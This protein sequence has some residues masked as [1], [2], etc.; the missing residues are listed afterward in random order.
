MESKKRA[1]GFFVGLLLFGGLL[2]MVQLL[3]FGSI[4]GFFYAS[5]DIGERYDYREIFYDGKG[6]FMELGEGS[7]FEVLVEKARGLENDENV[8]GIDFSERVWKSVDGGMSWV[9]IE[10][11]ENETYVMIA[12]DNVIVLFENLGWYSKDGGESWD[13]L[14]S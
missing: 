14:K 3:Y 5:P 8:F 7:G 6:D 2:M 10:A 13:S 9:L 4:A 12:D 11:G 1:I